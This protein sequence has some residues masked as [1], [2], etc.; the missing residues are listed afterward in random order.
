MIRIPARSAAAAATANVPRLV[1][2]SFVAT[3]IGGS[4]SR[5]ASQHGRTG[6]ELSGVGQVADGFARPCRIAWDVLDE[7]ARDVALRH[8]DGAWAGVAVPA[9]D[10]ERAEVDHR[11]DVVAAAAERAEGRDDQRDDAPVVLR[12][13]RPVDRCRA[14]A[15]TAE[16]PVLQPLLDLPHG[17]ARLRLDAGPG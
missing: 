17:A 2:I 12:V 10:V 6:R 11:H 9:D 5:L 14:R 4:S 7:V 15:R 13:V 8:R 3:F 16:N 1:E